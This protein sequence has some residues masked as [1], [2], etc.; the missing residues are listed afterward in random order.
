M[1][2]RALII[3]TIVITIGLTAFGIHKRQ[4]DVESCDVKVEYALLAQTDPVM[5]YFNFY[6]PEVSASV[7]RDLFYMV[8][9]R[10]ERPTTKDQLGKA[11]ILS[12]FIPN[13]P[14]SWISDY[15]SVEI[16]ANHNGKKMIAVS[17]NDVLNYEQKNLLSTIDL[18][19]DI[20]INVNYK[21]QNCITK[22]ADN[23]QMIVSMT[24][25]PEKEAEYIGGYNQMINYLR[26]NSSD[27]I[28]GH[29]LEVFQPS[30]ILF[31][32][33]E[34]GEVDNVILNKTTGNAEV[35]KF[36]VELIGNMPNW[37]PAENSN[38]LAVKQ[39]FEFN[40]GLDGC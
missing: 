8:R 12:D 24:V 27:E 37:D 34:K 31:T 28:T 33:N 7:N 35:D 18:A 14:S 15:T 40:L 4:F 22:H 38:G 13:Y 9:G 32:V 20:L 11:T 1:K 5:N 19:D 36:L 10:Y 23:R 30:S 29:N 2:K 25:I 26:E 17:Q 21:S 39:Q 16:I 3:T 6:Q